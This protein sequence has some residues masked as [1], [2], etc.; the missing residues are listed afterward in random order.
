[1]KEV[2]LPLGSRGGYRREGKA[3]VRP[4]NTFVINPKGEGSS[5]MGGRCG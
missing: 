3:R 1:M 4:G 5:E 2:L